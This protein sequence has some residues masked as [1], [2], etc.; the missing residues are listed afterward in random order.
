MKIF[1]KSKWCAWKINSIVK[2]ETDDSAHYNFVK[3]VSPKL[4]VL[5]IITRQCLTLSIIL[6]V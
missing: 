1:L 5:L 2:H 3:T 4:N 6:I